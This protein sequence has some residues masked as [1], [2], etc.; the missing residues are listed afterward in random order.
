MWKTL[1]D[2]LHA[3]LNM[4][5]ELQ[6]HRVCLRQLEGR[7]R[8]TEESVKLLALELRHSREVDAA[9]REKLLS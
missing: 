5:R 8:D 2:W 7:I 1:A 3:F 9:A 4:T 6:E